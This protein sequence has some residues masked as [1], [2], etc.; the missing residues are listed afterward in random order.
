MIGNPKVLAKQALWHSLITHFRDRKVLVEGP[1]AS[2]KPCMVHLGNPRPMRSGGRFVNPALMEL[3]APHG[4]G[5]PGDG[6]GRM[7]DPYAMGQMP[8]G[9][10]PGECAHP[11]QCAL[12]R[13]S[14]ADSLPCE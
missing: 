6:R 12:T 2:L 9:M 1:L 4:G 3:T 8:M 10:H 13:S 5:Q 11:T 14:P 7:G